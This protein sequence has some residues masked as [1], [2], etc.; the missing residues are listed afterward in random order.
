MCSSDL[1]GVRL[2]AQD[3]Q[4]MGTLKPP[5]SKDDTASDSGTVLGVDLSIP[6]ASNSAKVTA[7]ALVLALRP[8]DVFMLTAAEAGGARLKLLLHA[9]AETPGVDAV[10]IRPKAP[11]PAPRIVTASVQLLS[12]SKVETLSFK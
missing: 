12:G 8:A 10:D 6:G 11:R 4:V 5:H 9:A 7:P 2:V 1:D 3:A